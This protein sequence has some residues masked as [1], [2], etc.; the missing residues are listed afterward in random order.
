MSRFTS[1]QKCASQIGVGVLGFG[2]PFC[3]SGRGTFAAV[4]TL[5]QLARWLGLSLS[6]CRGTWSAP[7][8]TV[9][10]FVCVVRGGAAW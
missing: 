7:L 4:A 6:W 3:V 10:G 1:F 8:G 2:C 9:T 5:R